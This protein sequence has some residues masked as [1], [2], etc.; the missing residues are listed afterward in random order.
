MTFAEF[1]SLTPADVTI[2]LDAHERR[3][4][5]NYW[6]TG[7]VTAAIVNANL[8][9]GGR[10]AKPDDFVPQPRRA[11]QARA[12]TPEQMASLFKLYTV[13]AGGEVMIRGN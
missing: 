11:Q 7:L 2:A 8:K 6:R 13:A 3:E 1:W 9:K 12:Q 4:R 10:A 5:A